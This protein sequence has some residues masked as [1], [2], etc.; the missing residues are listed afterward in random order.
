MKKIH[1]CLQI[2]FKVIIFTTLL[3]CSTG[4]NKPAN[5]Y[6]EE[7]L[8][9]YEQMEYDKSIESFNKVLELAQYGKD[10]NLVYYNRAMAHLKNRQYDKSIYDFTKTLE[11]TSSGDKKLKFDILS[12]R[13]EAY[14]KSNQFDH[15]IKDY[16]DAIALFPGHKN[17]KYIYTSRAW[18]WYIKG[19]FTSAIDDFSKAVNIDPEFDDAYYGR[20]KVWVEK[21]DYQRASDDAKEALRLKPTNRE[22]RDL[23]FK[24]K[25][26]MDQ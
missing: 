4:Y 20:A 26:S 14:Q 8:L 25:S 12:F 19:E 1:H 23:L 10:N 2:S 15:A 7:G 22:Y 11:L 24:I 13:G 17:I 5:Q 16:S 18:S 6:Y 9:F 21:K 3:S